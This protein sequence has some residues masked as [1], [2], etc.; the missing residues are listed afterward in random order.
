MSWA[1]LALIRPPSSLQLDCFVSDG[2]RRWFAQAFFTDGSGG[3]WAGHH[4]VMRC[5]LSIIG[6]AWSL[7]AG[8]NEAVIA[9]DLLAERDANML[10]DVTFRGGSLIPESWCV[11]TSSSVFTGWFNGSGVRDAFGGPLPGEQSALP[12]ELMAIL[13]AL[14]HARVDVSII[15]VA[16]SMIVVKGLR[17]GLSSGHVEV[18]APLC[19]TI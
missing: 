12:S 18:V 2:L 15:I 10:I 8:F 17:G 5:A 7:I 1:E 3:R 14:L 11:T 6:M 4:F 13:V 19:K 9:C 16:D